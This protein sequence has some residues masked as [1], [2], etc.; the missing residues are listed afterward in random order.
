MGG[1]DIMFRIK[2]LSVDDITSDML[3]NFH[4]QIINKKYVRQS[5][6]WEVME[7][8]EL[9]QW[10]IEKRVWIAEYLCQQIQRGGSV[11]GAYDTDVLVGFCSVD[12]YLHGITSKYAN[13]TMLFIDDEFKRRGIGKALFR[14][15]GKYAS[16]SGADKL[17]ISAIPSIE[18]VEFYFNM[19]C[20]EAGEIIVDY[21]DT[22]NDRYLEYLLI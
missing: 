9:R 22:E 8:D 6:E 10:S 13:L 11:I 15:I 18:T 14:E 7:C 4:H 5:N 12:G 17:F 3:M 20:I 16:K 2:K 19:G 1:H 21:I